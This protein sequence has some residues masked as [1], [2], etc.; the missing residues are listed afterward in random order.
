MAYDLFA[1]HQR[2]CCMCF[3]GIIANMTRKKSVHIVWCLLM[4]Y[5]V[6]VRTDIEW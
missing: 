5:L 3:V 6:K 1:S 4:F 2:L